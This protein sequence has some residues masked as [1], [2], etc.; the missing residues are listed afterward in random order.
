MSLRYPEEPIM[1]TGLPRAV[2]A[3]FRK[4]GAASAFGHTLAILIV[5]QAA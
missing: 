2:L 3:A 5:Y 1:R 4:I